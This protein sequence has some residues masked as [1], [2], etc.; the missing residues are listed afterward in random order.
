MLCPA[1]MLGY[2]RAILESLSRCHSACPDAGRERSVPRLC[3]CAKRRD[4]KGLPGR[5]LVEPGR[6]V[7]EEPLFD[8]EITVAAPSPE[9][10]GTRMYAE[11][12]EL[13]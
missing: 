8:F 1:N 7:V 2:L 4:P 6:S 10:Y 11:C 13:A 9:T 5:R 12:G 3:S